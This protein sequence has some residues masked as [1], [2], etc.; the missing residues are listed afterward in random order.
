[1]LDSHSYTSSQKNHNKKKSDL[2]QNNMIKKYHYFY[3][4]WFRS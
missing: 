2:N 4:P 3:Q 1:V